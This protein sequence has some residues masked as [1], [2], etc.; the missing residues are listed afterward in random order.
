MSDMIEHALPYST[1]CYSNIRV[2][3]VIRPVLC[4]YIYI[5]LFH[6]ILKMPSRPAAT[7]HLLQ[8]KVRLMLALRQLL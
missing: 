7:L 5:I 3:V 1:H 6:A 2:Q 8:V 4:L